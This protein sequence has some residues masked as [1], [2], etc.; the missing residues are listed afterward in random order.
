MGWNTLNLTLLSELF[1]FSAQTNTEA[2]MQR[3]H[4][5]LT[6]VKGNN[7]KPVLSS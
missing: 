4:I 6:Q 2:K 1:I 3:Q 7:K 5:Y